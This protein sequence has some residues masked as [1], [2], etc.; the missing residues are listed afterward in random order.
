MKDEDTVSEVHPVQ[1]IT[2]DRKQATA[3]TC[4]TMAAYEVYCAVYNPQPAMV[5]GECRGGF[6]SGEIIAFLYARSFPRAEWRRRVDEAFNGLHV[7]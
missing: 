1:A 2:R 6:S 3:P 7:G 4:V 5:T